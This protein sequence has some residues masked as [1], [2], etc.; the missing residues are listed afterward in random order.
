MHSLGNC[1]ECE[2]LCI[3]RVSVETLCPDCSYFTNRLK[4]HWDAQYINT[5]SVLLLWHFPG[6]LDLQVYKT[7]SRHLITSCSSWHS[8]RSEKHHTKDSD[9]KSRSAVRIAFY[10]KETLLP[11]EFSLCHDM[12]LLLWWVAFLCEKS[13]LSLSQFLWNRKPTM[14]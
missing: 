1:V 5:Q 6:N 2:L 13:S 10:S 9:K 12:L 4:Y 8:L 11:V 7:L 3:K 14:F